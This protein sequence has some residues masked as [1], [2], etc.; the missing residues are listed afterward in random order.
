MRLKR[1]EAEPETRLGICCGDECRE[2]QIAKG[3]WNYALLFKVPGI[4]R[5]R[6]DGCFARETGGRHHL[7]VDLDTV[8]EEELEAA[9]QMHDQLVQR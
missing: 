8:T 6:C 4:S 2:A 3:T 9:A 5:Y 7:A 1:G